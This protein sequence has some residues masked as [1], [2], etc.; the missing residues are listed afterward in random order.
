MDGF[1]KKD[2]CTDLL[3]FEVSDQIAFAIDREKE[4]KGWKRVRNDDPIKVENPLLKDLAI[5]WF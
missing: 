2:N 3:F 1:T 5:D 4:I